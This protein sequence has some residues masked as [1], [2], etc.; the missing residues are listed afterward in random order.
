MQA[1][2]ILDSI[3]R[4]YELGYKNRNQSHFLSFL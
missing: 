4:D 1:P 2:A 3:M